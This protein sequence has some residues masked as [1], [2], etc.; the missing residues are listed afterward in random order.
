MKAFRGTLLAALVLLIVA[1]LRENI[2]RFEKE[3]GLPE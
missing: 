1:G 2:N 3:C